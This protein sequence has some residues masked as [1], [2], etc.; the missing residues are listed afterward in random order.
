MYIL[1]IKPVSVVLRLWL[2]FPCRPVTFV[3]DGGAYDP[4]ALIT[5]RAHGSEWQHGLFDHGRFK[6][7]FFS[8]SFF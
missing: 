7:K 8:F 4:R 1:D 5:G 3:P 2:I 6:K